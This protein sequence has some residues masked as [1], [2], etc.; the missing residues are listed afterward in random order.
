MLKINKDGSIVEASLP[1]HG[2][3]TH[4]Y[5]LYR[6]AVPGGLLV[7]NTFTDEVWFVLDSEDEGGGR[8]DILSRL[9]EGPSPGALIREAELTSERVKSSLPYEIALCPIGGYCSG[10]C[11][12]SAEADF[13]RNCTE[14]KENFGRLVETV[15]A[16]RLPTLVVGLGRAAPC[17]DELFSAFYAQSRQEILP[18]ELDF[19]RSLCCPRDRVLEIGAGSGFIS[20][21]YAAMPGLTLTLIEP[22]P[23]NLSRLKTI[24]ATSSTS[25]EVFAGIFQ[26][27]PV[28]VA[29]DLVVTSWDTLV[30]FDNRTKEEFFSFVAKALRPGGI[31]ATHLSSLGW[32]RLMAARLKKPKVFTTNIQ[33]KNFEVTYR[34]DQVGDD[35]YN[36]TI[37]LR[38]PEL[39]VEK[40]YILP[41]LVESLENTLIRASAAGLQLS[42]KMSD[43]LGHDVTDPSDHVL[44]FQKPIGPTSAACPTDMST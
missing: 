18:G 35:F 20:Q 16:S 25:V 40:R 43:F 22:E 4:A 44:V 36:K 2:R 39:R 31:F 13:Q 33:G 1:P 32:N 41:T 37:I 19:W 10:G 17:W 7:I 38:S 34:I 21:A 15:I 11:R 9:A 14:E 23:A 42:R 30:M 3:G 6:K 26:D 28:N 29:F 27:F 24:S 12:L 5:P 8:E